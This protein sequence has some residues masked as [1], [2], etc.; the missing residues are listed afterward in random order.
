MQSAY[1]EQIKS[2]ASAL[3]SPANEA[4]RFGYRRALSKLTRRLQSI[5]LLRIVDSVSITEFIESNP[6]TCLIVY[7]QRF[8]ANMR[9]LEISTI[10]LS[11]TGLLA[12]A[13]IPQD[14]FLKTCTN[15]PKRME[16]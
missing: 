4:Q 5:E 14:G 16:W 8:L 15:P 12:A 13:A 3:C 2:L 1:S 10:G 9:L 11:L 6:E 7:P